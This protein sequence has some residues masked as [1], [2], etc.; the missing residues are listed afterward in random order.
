VF[1]HRDRIAIIVL[2]DGQVVDM[3]DRGIDR[4]LVS[5]FGRVVR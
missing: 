2:P 1:L 3:G 5:E 4:V